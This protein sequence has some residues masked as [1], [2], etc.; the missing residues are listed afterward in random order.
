[1][2]HVMHIVALIAPTNTLT[3]AYANF[4]VYGNAFQRHYANLSI[5]ANAPLLSTTPSDVDERSRARLHE[6]LETSDK[7]N[8]SRP[9][10]A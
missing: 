10:F 5:S 3:N 9:F 6:S 7:C 4:P 1:M 2:P 8:E